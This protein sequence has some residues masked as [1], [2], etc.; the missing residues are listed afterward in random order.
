MKHLFLLCL[1]S[2]YSLLVEA[3]VYKSTTSE[4]S[5]FSSAPLE[6]ITALNKSTKA[7]INAKD[8]VFAIVITIKDFIFPN[9]TM[10]SHF[11]ENYLESEKYPNATFKGKI[12]GSFNLKQNGVYNVKVDG[13]LKIH[14]VEQK[15]VIA[16]KITVKDGM[17]NTESDFMVKLE[18]HKIKIP[19]A[20]FQNIAEEV[21]VTAKINYVLN[22]TKK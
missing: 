16:A 4:V 21:K 14:G 9:A 15:R 13:I 7:A 19:T 12:K 17:I 18:N 6:D 1:I 8:S 2:T 10:Q 11:N 3:Q 5:F 20:V 22:E